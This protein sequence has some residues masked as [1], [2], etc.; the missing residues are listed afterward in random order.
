MSFIQLMQSGQRILRNEG[1][2]PLVRQT[3]E[4]FKVI[5]KYRSAYST[6]LKKHQLNESD[7]K[8]MKALIKSF[9]Y[10][11]KISIITP[12]YNV[13]KN[14]LEK[15]IISVI[16]QVYENWE[17][18]LVDD[19]ST[20]P[21]IRYILE[22]Y[23]KKDSRIKVKFLEENGGISNASNEALSIAT[24]EFAGF[25]DHDDELSI[26][27]LFEVIKLLNEHLD[28]DMIYSDEDHIKSNGK[29]IDPNFKPDW[30]P[31]LFLSSMYTCHFGVYR[32]QLIDDVG[33]FRKGFEGSQDYDL[34]LRLTEKTDR[35]YHIPLI[36]YHWRKTPGSTANRYQS[37]GY[38]DINA[39]RALEDALKRRN[40][41]GDI[42]PGRFPGL[43]NVRREIIGNPSVSIIIPTKDNVDML[44]KCIESIRKRTDYENYEII[45]IDNNSK[46]PHTI[47]Y[48][49]SVSKTHS[50]RVLRY[51]NP[52]NF[53]AIN[54][55][56]AKNSH[57]EYILFLNND[58]EVITSVWLSAM[59][60]HAQRNEVGAVGCKLLYPDKTIQHAGIILGIRGEK[61]IPGVAGHS[62]KH[63][64]NEARGYF[65]RPH[66]IQNLSAVTAAC[67]MIR[68]GIFEEA[69][70]FDE[71]LA[72]AF[73]DVDL[74]LN[75]RKKGYLIVYTP[76]AELYHHESLSRGYENSP[77][78]I[79][80][81]SEEFRYMREKWG[82][83]IDQGDPY[84]NPNL[85]LEYEDFRIKI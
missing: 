60:E 78:K 7:I 82:Q 12:V 15:A 65:H 46:D 59:L 10:S 27:A 50:V 75:L 38:A 16:N 24:G 73:N 63:L 36:L 85:S 1:L 44:K 42:L 69:G 49:E 33:G 13:D 54:N 6:Y 64:P 34:V 47:E 11:P 28:A 20:K 35:I 83:L 58:T 79:M 31:D 55:H 8:T 41:K 3:V 74:C 21:H 25:L 77:D 81:F 26:N 48:L 39:R 57:S 51:E 66:M 68:K 62:H 52:F 37:K 80:R 18:C 29:F 67:M 30:S 71:K 14:L 56:A 23:E 17:L 43:F 19:A 84:Y 40:I 32:R 5:G 76:C 61:G 9:K 53:S 72:L 2:C 22:K 45:I 70:G 4:H